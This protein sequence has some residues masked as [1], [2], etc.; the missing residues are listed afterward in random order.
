[1]AHRRFL[2]VNDLTFWLKSAIVIFK[3]LANN[4]EGIV[5]KGEKDG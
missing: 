5:I 4:G 2:G 3:R 1:M